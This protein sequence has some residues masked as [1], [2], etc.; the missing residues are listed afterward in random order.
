[1]DLLSL[2][3]AVLPQAILVVV[4]VVCLLLYLLLQP[5]KEPRHIPAV[6][7]WVSLLPLIKDVDQ[8]VIYN[9]YIR[10]LLLEHGAIK[11]FF[12]SQWNVLVQRSTFL[13][14]VFKHEDLYQKSGNQKKIPGSVLASFLGD[15]IIS[16]H[17]GVWKLYQDIMKP[18]LQEGWSLSPIY[19]SASMLLEHFKQTPSPLPVQEPLQRYT[20]SNLVRVL[21]HLN[22]DMNHKETIQL[23]QMQSKVKA[24]IFRPLF[25][26]FPFLDTW[27]LRSREAARRDAAQFTDHLVCMLAGAWFEKSDEHHQ[28]DSQHDNIGHRLVS[29]WEEGRIS[30][31]QLRDNVTVLFVAGQENPQLAILSTLYLIAKHP[32]VQERLHSEIM[33]TSGNRPNEEQLRNM[34]Y[35]TACV[36]ESLRLLPPIGQL[37]NRLATTPLVLG[38]DTVV[39]QGMYL[40]Y[41]SYATNRDPSVWGPDAEE[42]LPDRWGE[43]ASDVQKSYRRRRA[44]AE[45]ITFHGGRRACLGERFALLQLKVTLSTLVRHLR[46][47]LDPSWPDRMTPA[48]PLAPR[49]LRLKFEQRYT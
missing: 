1:M 37:I 38:E 27:G 7:F 31:Q 10:D 39:P 21:M 45:F 22:I 2:I 33:N 14:Q 24:Q 11:I 16:S 47:E 35:L 19:E 15:N 44:R 32:T 43:T 3:P 48:G 5:P 23:S 28:D 20:I 34:P 30:Y 49:G 46:W 26:S 13:S 8:Q 42:F 18:G 25:M 40:G 41:N 12:G 9:T 17:G 29:A 4:G 6:P 36:Y